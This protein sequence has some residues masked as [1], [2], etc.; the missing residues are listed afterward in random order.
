MSSA[1]D[2][3]T[4]FPV[5]APL[6]EEQEGMRASV[7]SKHSNTPPPTHAPPH[8]PSNHHHSISS[9]LDHHTAVSAHPAHYHSVASSGSPHSASHVSPAPLSSAGAGVTHGSRHAGSSHPVHHPRSAGSSRVSPSK[10]IAH[11][12][13]LSA[14]SPVT[15]RTENASGFP[16]AHA[17]SSSERD[18]PHAPWS[19]TPQLPQGTLL[20]PS[21]SGTSGTS[22]T[23]GKGRPLEYRGDHAPA[24]GWGATLGLEKYRGDRAANDSGDRAEEDALS[25]SGTS[26]RGRSISPSRSPSLRTAAIAKRYSNDSSGRVLTP[27]GAR[28]Q[29]AAN[30][31]GEHAP[32]YNG[33]RAL[34]ANYNADYAGEDA[35][36]PTTLPNWSNVRDHA[37]SYN[38]D[39]ALAG[40]DALSPTT[41]TARDADRGRGGSW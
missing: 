25:P 19:A 32:S 37:A 36:S 10:S 39:Y 7:P 29:P 23:W 20:A 1:E 38:G 6:L 31:N 28:T 26:G 2:R 17:P 27:Y 12:R 18:A 24:P 34:A 15:S 14:A 16:S 35:L 33:D 11:G 41:L 30:Y 40:E 13:P 22:G 5:A 8:H 4:V 9:H 21:P 3:K